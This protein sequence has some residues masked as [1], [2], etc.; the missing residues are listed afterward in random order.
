MGN[1]HFVK[2]PSVYSV[3]KKKTHLHQV[4]PT[5]EMEDEDLR[6]LKKSPSLDVSNLDKFKDMFFHGESKKEAFDF[7]WKHFDGD[8]FSLWFVEYICPFEQKIKTNMSFQELHGFLD[9]LESNRDEVFGN[10]GLFGEGQDLEIKGIWLWKGD[11]VPTEVMK[12]KNYQCFEF[13]KLDDED[14]KDRLEST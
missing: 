11:G 1:F 8:R 13:T 2:S 3:K 7:F 6:V 12:I 5:P 14:E 4:E 10:F 9:A